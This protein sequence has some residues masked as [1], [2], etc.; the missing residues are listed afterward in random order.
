MTRTA[1][2]RRLIALIAATFAMAAAPL[3]PRGSPRGEG[4]P[5]AAALAAV[6]PRRM[7]VVV[8]RREPTV[9]VAPPAAGGG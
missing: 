5:L 1:S 6:P 9:V 2:I 8:E 7:R 4:Q 3:V